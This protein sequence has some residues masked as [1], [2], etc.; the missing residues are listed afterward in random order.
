MRSA[1]FLDRDGTLNREVDY[2]ADPADLELIGSAARALGNARRAGHAIVIITNQ[3]G[4]ARGLLTEADLSAIHARLNELLLAADP[5][6]RVDGYYACPHH[7]DIGSAPYRLNCTCRKPKP[8][9]FLQAARDLGL[10]L[11]RS[12]MVGDSI[13]DLDAARAA[14]VPA[15]YLVATGKG[16]AQ[17]GDLAA[18][19]RFAPDVLAAVDAWLALPE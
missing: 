8:G 2:L 15:R 1:L 6:A 12:A 4:I 3:S 16:T 10:D 13:R 9:L 7:P 11:V 5:D 17:H 19:D 18:D 14:G